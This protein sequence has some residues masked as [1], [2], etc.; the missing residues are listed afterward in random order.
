MLEVGA[1]DKEKKQGKV[2]ETKRG[3]MGKLISLFLGRNLLSKSPTPLLSFP[4]LTGKKIGLTLLLGLSLTEQESDGDGC[5]A[6]VFYGVF[7]ENID[8]RDR[9]T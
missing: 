8:A 2:K 7:P 3:K 9:Q 4:L 1:Q 6:L 5:G